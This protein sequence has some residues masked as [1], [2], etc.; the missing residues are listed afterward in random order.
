MI[1]YIILIKKQII[2]W[3]THAVFILLKH[4]QYIYISDID[5][6]DVYFDTRHVFFRIK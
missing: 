3:Y 5:N 2:F 6:I 4:L 1:I